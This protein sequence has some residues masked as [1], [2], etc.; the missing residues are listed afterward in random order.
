MTIA[1]VSYPINF[2][3]QF[4]VILQLSASYPRGLLSKVL[5]SPLAKKKETTHQ[6]GILT[7]SLILIIALILTLLKDSSKDMPP[8]VETRRDGS[9]KLHPCSI[10][11]ERLTLTLTLTLTLI[12]SVKLHP[13]S[14]NFERKTMVGLRVRFR[15][16]L[17]IRVRFRVRIM[18]RVRFRVRVMK[19]TN[20]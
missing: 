11:F 6:K 17:R 3:G 20:D 13:C 12:G 4:T 16:W 10:N 19:S 15:V 9:V 5:P 8:K 1:T 7:S 2:Y 14:I 18:V